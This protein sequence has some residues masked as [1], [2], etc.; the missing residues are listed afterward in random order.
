[1]RGIIGAMAFDSIKDLSKTEP[2]KGVS[3]NI[4]FG[5]QS[6]NQLYYDFDKENQIVKMEIYPFKA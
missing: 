1:M 2:S 4:S 3:I 6:L 5:E